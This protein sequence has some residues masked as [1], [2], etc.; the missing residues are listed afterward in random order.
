MVK[1]EE[2]GW[3]KIKRKKKYLKVDFIQTMDFIFKNVWVIDCKNIK[4]LKRK[5]KRNEVISIINNGS[6]EHINSSYIMYLG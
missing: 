6:L 3:K 2:N 5:I 1:K 4:Q